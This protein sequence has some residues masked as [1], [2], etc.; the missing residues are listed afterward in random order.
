MNFKQW[1]LISEMAR[2]FSPKYLET[3]SLQ[4]LSETASDPL[5][6]RYKF[7]IS[8]WDKDNNTLTPSDLTPGSKQ[9]INWKCLKKEHTWEAPLFSRTSN[10]NRI[11][12]TNCPCCSSAGKKRVC[13]DNNLQ[14]LSENSPDDDLKA[15]YQFLV[16]EWDGPKN[17]K[18]DGEPLLPKDVTPGGD[19]MIN[20]KCEKGHE[21]EAVL[22]SRSRTNGANCPCCSSTHKKVCNDNNL[23]DLSENSPDDDLKDRYKRM[24]SEWDYGKDESGKF[25]NKKD[26]GEPLL[27]KDVTVSGRKIINWKCLEK[28]H[29]WQSTL[30]DRTNG[31]NNCPCCSNRQ[32]CKDNNLQ[33]LSENLPESDL[34]A[35]YQRLVSEW[36]T[37]NNTLTP[38]DVTPGTGQFINWKCKKGHTWEA[39]LVSRTGLNL[40]TNCPVCNESKGEQKTYEILQKYISQTQIKRQF[41]DENCR[42]DCLPLPFDFIVEIN[43]KKYFIEYNGEPHYRPIFGSTPEERQSNFEKRQRYDKV[44][45]DYCR[46]KNIPFLV[47]PYTKYKNIDTIISSF[48]KTKTF[49]S[50]FAELEL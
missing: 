19:K 37:D 21:W 29:E 22:Y 43:G 50:K 26:D 35:R 1:L 49:D 28:E 2:S 25:K 7:L 13:N 4:A 23:Q 38:S 10:N 17:K 48:L 31:R 39:S 16:S 27:P 47:I 40:K 42:G 12:G 5:K 44:K 36:D 20:W 33:A 18:D 46:S 6:T 32:V 41:K 9:I 30:N 15:R 3:N 8:E 11:S 45:L 14:Y 24:V 34:K